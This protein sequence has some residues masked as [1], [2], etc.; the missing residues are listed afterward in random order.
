MNN[1]TKMSAAVVAAILTS[2]SAIAGHAVD[3]G[4]IGGMGIPPIQGLPG[5]P[6]GVGGGAS[7]SGG[8]GGTSHGSSTNSGGSIYESRHNLKLSSAAPRSN[9]PTIS[10]HQHVERHADQGHGADLR[11]P[12]GRR[13]GQ[14]H[15][16]VERCAGNAGQD[17]RCLRRSRG[18]RALHGQDCL[19]PQ[20]FA[21]AAL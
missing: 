15:P 16:A 20:A 11:H 6:S 5:V 9:S 3:F 21:F 17:R 19:T 4:G 18:R 10:G 2:S 13:E 14:L 8:T 1:L 12:V 7:G